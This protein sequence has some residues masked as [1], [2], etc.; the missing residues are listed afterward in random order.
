VWR[1][2]SRPARHVS[3]GHLCFVGA[4]FEIFSTHLASPLQLPSASVALTVTPPIAAV[5]HVEHG[6]VRLSVCAGMRTMPR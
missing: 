6:V 3:T 4:F 1:F 5:I 2:S